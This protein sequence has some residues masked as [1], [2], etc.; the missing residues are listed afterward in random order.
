[1]TTAAKSWQCRF[2]L[3]TL[4]ESC[5]GFFGGFFSLFVKVKTRTYTQKL[6]D[7]Y[8][9]IFLVA[10]CAVALHRNLFHQADPLAV[11]Q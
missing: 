9:P 8:A 5:F 1:M 4:C 11:R 2:Y 3:L 10:R 7:C 6:Q